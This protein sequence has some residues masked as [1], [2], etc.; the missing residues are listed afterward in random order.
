M[1]ERTER[2][3]RVHD[4][5][6]LEKANV[7]GVAAGERELLVLVEEKKPL[8]E[9]AE[10]DVVDP[11]VEGVE[12]D[13]IETGPI[14]AKFKPGT[15]I[16]L[17]NAGTGTLGGV[18]FDEHGTAYGLTNNHVAANVNRAMALTS[19]HSP[20]AAD[21]LGGEIGVL[22]RFEPMYFEPKYTP[23][24]VDAA[25]VRLHHKPSPTHPN[26]VLTAQV[27]WSLV[28]V[29]RTSGRT[30]GKVKGRNASVNVGMG[31]QGVARFRGCVITTYMLDA[32]DSGS[33]MTTVGGY[34]CALGFAGSSTISIANPMDL[35]LRTLGVSF[36]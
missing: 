4:D 31:S 12:T 30:T 11:V 28:K 32:G 9:L 33:V 35:V 25:L 23:N 24:Y 16:G 14:T 26:R 10:E 34:A 3:A 1:S 19:V 21:G 13:V 36:R 7:V 20:G 5:R 22:G 29:G 18:V 6:L 27:G 17:R 15:S 2:L 8:E